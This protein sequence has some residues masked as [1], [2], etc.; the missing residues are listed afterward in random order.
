MTQ[1]ASLDLQITNA[2]LPSPIKWMNIAF[3]IVLCQPSRAIQK[4]RAI[5]GCVVG[6]VKP[7]QKLRVQDKGKSKVPQPI[8]NVQS[9]MHDLKQAFDVDKENVEG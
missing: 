4:L 5:H 2:P 9:N 3:G 1:W 8:G 6:E 7:I